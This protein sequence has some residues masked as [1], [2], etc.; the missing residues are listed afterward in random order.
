MTIRNIAVA[1]LSR[2]A[3][4][5]GAGL[6]VAITMGMGI[7]TSKA[8]VDWPHKTVTMIVPFKPGGS[9]DRLARFLA[10]A[11]SEQL[12][13]NVKVDNRPGG[14]GRIGYQQ[15][16]AG[17]DDGSVFVLGV[18]PYLS[19]SII[20]PNAKY[21]LED[22]AF[23]AVQENDPIS[24]TVHKD[25]PY[26]SLG[27]I[28]E[29]ARKNPDTITIGV[30]AGG[31]PQLQ[32]QTIAGILD[33]FPYREV[34][35]EGSTYRNALLGKHVDVVF[36]SASGDLAIKDNAK[37]VAIASDEPFPGWESAEPINKALKPYGV[38][39]PYIGA[40][41]FVAF[42]TSFR[43][44]HP[45]L[46]TA[47]IEAYKKAVNSPKFRENITKSGEI[48]V[49]RKDPLDDPRGLI[50]DNLSAIQKYKTN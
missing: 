44:K 39:V 18:D 30:P 8:G 22:W 42:K 49:T 40:I 37:V 13:V 4:L 33:G 45:D 23:V 48:V 41:R 6:V 38:D 20:A 31:G 24:I 21:N 2:R 28:I 3:L 15:V 43:E 35:Y 16:Q 5:V 14:K 12:G 50:K 25:S 27:E 7:P 19:Q 10:P 11:L 9:V 1:G 46:W 34:T 36:S 47:F 26:N 17:P 29:A 32:L